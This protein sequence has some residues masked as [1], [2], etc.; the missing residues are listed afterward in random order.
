MDLFLYNGK[1]YTMD[2]RWPRADSLAVRDG[3]ILAVGPGEVVAAYLGKDVEAI[4]LGGR[5]VVPGLVDAHFHFASWASGLDEVDLS[6]AGSLEEALVLIAKA[7]AETPPAFKAPATAGVPAIAA[8]ATAASSTFASGRQGWPRS[9]WIRGY[10]WN[11]NAW[12]DRGIPTREHLDKV[13]A[14]RPA[15]FTV[16]MG[17][18]LG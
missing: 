1:V 3:K 8:T 15:F 13:T 7:A 2:Q 12:Q 4:D 5:M 14:G 18:Q 9:A 17:T 6:R 16:R 11:K 10:G